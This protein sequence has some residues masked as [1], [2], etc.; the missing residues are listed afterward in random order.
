MGNNITRSKSSFN[1]MPEKIKPGFFFFLKKSIAS[2]NRYDKL[3]LIY[4]CTPAL[5]PIK[6]RSS[7]C[8]ASSSVTECLINSMQG[9]S[10]L[11]ITCFLRAAMH[12]AD[13]IWLRRAIMSVL[14][15]HI[16][17]TFLLTSGPTKGQPSAERRSISACLQSGWQ[18]MVDEGT[19]NNLPLADIQ[20]L[21]CFH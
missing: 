8:V 21:I 18:H 16:H 17:A 14:M 10:G 7:D 12:C 13:L 15:P 9:I 19:T 5:N 20:R 1:M 6:K 11:A 2:P 4:K 3:S